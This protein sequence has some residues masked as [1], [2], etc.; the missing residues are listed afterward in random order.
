MLD[1]VLF[2]SCRSFRATLQ[3]RILYAKPDC[4]EGMAKTSKWRKDFTEYPNLRFAEG[5]R[6]IPKRISGAVLADQPHAVNLHH[7]IQR[8]G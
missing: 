7:K 1:F 8:Q 6:E 4:V 3:E 2:P 5:C